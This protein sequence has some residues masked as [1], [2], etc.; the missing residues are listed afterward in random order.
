MCEANNFR[1]YRKILLEHV[2]QDGGAKKHP[3]QLSFGKS[4]KLSLKPADAA[5][6]Y[7]DT[8]ADIN[9]VASNPLCGPEWMV[10]LYDP[11]TEPEFLLYA[12]HRVFKKSGKTPG[13]DGLTKADYADSIHLMRLISDLCAELK[14]RK[15]KPFPTRRAWIRK[16]DGGKRP[17]E[18][19][20]IRDRIVQT[21]I[22]LLIDPV[23][24]RHLSESSFAFRYRMGPRLA[25]EK[26]LVEMAK[27]D[28]FWTFSADIV[29]CFDSIN[30]TELL[31]DFTTYVGDPDLIKLVER[32]LTKNSIQTA[33]NFD[34]ADSGIPQG[35]NI[36][37][38]MA[39]LYLHRLDRFF[40]ET[41]AL[42]HN[43]A[44]I[45]Y[46]DD[47]VI[48]APKPI[49]DLPDTIESFLTLQ[50]LSVHGE[51]KKP[52]IVDIRQNGILRF[53]GYEIKKDKRSDGFLIIQPKSKRCDNLVNSVHRLINNERKSDWS[54]PVGVLA[55]RINNHL[56]HFN[57]YYKHT[58][59]KKPFNR[60]NY[61]IKR[62]LGIHPYFKE[63]WPKINQ[64]QLYVD[65]G[66]IEDTI[67]HIDAESYEDS[68]EEVELPW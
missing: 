38:L 37:P 50:G 48:L 40:Y 19:A 17:I 10:G 56:V 3:K 39:N 41:I 13:V 32:F 7:W 22:A 18:I 64:L 54:L 25:F 31:N 63:L 8:I 14:D 34:T 11:L 42:K 30:R 27:K 44:L 15:Y 62:L 20:T 2:N 6:H 43:A 4:Q 12:A 45:R 58:N 52:N 57:H 16:S 33:Y 53:L 68:A 47:F 60:V 66:S 9:A 67:L 5:S 49:P 26:L 1:E 59:V 24:D 35:S 51:T 61:S 28:R 36:S 55:N 21:A 29:A 65:K 23:I 46:A